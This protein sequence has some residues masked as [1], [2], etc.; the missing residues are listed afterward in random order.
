MPSKSIINTIAYHSCRVKAI[1]KGVCRNI[2]FLAGGE[3]PEKFDDVSMPIIRHRNKTPQFCAI[4]PLLHKC[5]HID[6]LSQKYNSHIPFILFKLLLPTILKNTPAG[7]SLRQ[8]THYGQLIKS[9]QFAK[10]DYGA[11]KNLRRYGSIYPPSYDLKNVRAPV[12]LVYSVNDL[13]TAVVDVQTLNDQLPNVVSLYEVE[14]R[15]FT[16][17]DFVWGLHAKEQVYD[18]VIEIMENG[19]L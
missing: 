19:S 12:N 14:D 4:K 6:T 2:I 16:H 7:S 1:A 18:H 10:Y 3:N 17:F 8:I 5:R 13:L 15:L 9:N 11:I